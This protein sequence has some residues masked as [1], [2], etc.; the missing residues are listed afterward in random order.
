MRMAIVFSLAKGLALKNKEDEAADKSIIM[1]GI[2]LAIILA[3]VTGPL[4]YA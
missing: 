1:A 4:M 3:G 2:A